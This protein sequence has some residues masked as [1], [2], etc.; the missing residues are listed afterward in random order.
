MINLLVVLV[1]PTSAP[2]AAA[3]AVTTGHEASRPEDARAAAA[4]DGLQF[5]GLELRRVALPEMRHHPERGT[6]TIE[7]TEATVVALYLSGCAFLI[8]GLW[9]GCVIWQRQATKRPA[10]ACECA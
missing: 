6:I 2:S 7:I 8:G 3:V 10:E 5:G 4:Q 9:I 1:A